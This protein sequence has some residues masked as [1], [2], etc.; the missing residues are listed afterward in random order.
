MVYVFP[1][2][3]K[4]NDGDYHYISGGQLIQLYRLDRTQCRI[5][6]YSWRGEQHYDGDKS[7]LK[8][9]PL[10]SGEYEEAANKLH[11]AL[12]NA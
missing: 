10:Q 8:V 2:Y 5:V 12:E 11:E 1:G 3:V 7:D 4:S 9:F 6:N